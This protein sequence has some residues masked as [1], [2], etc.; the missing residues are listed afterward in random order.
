ME[1]KVSQRLMATHTYTNDDIAYHDLVTLI[2]Q[3]EFHD[4]SEAAL[5]SERDHKFAGYL[6]P[7][8]PYLLSTLHSSICLRNGNGGKGH[9]TKH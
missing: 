1:D 9:A 5:K 3:V 8:P 6:I 2:H 7:N 4:I